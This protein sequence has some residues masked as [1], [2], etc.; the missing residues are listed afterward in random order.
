MISF[1]V[2]VFNTSSFLEKC[3]DSIFNQ[4]LNIDEFEVITINDGSTDNSKDI[5]EKWKLTH[6][7]LI[8]ISQENQGLSI[9]RNRGISIA[10]G[11]YIQFVDSD[12]WLNP[13]MVKKCIDICKLNNLDILSFNMQKVSSS[14]EKSTKIK[15]IKFEGQIYSGEYLLTNAIIEAPV[16]KYIIKRGL[17]NKNQLSFHPYILHEDEEFTPRML[18]SAKKVMIINEVVYNY[19]VRTNSITQDLKK[20]EQSIAFKQNALFLLNANLKSDIYTP[21]QEIALGNKMNQLIAD[22]YITIA[23]LDNC[24]IHYA[25]FKQKLKEEKIEFRPTKNLTFN[26][27]IIWG[28]VKNKIGFYI[29]SIILKKFY[30][31][32]L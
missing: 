18:L 23:V 14:G 8:I 19:F 3:L 15:N 22:I 28:S 9:A 2:P 13:Q 5:L 7:N 29:I 1:I 27:L 11:E 16:W 25:N 12:D 21:S 4:C 26:G 10:K 32:Y 31:I 24:L 20:R 17:I 30:N 6:Q